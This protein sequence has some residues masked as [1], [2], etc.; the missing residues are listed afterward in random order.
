MRYVIAQVLGD[1]VKDTVGRGAAPRVH[2]HGSEPL[3]DP[4]GAGPARGPDRL[5]DGAP[6]REREVSVE[7]TPQRLVGHHAHDAHRDHDRA[8][9]LP[10]VGP[11]HAPGGGEV[12]TPPQHERQTGHNEAGDH[13]GGGPG[14]Q[15]PC[16]DR[17]DRADP[18]HPPHQAPREEADRERERQDHGVRQD[19]A[20]GADPGEVARR[21]FEDVRPGEVSP[22]GIDRR[23]H[24]EHRAAH[25]AASE[26]P[27]PRIGGRDRG[28][29]REDDVETSEV[30][31]VRAVDRPR[32]RREA[33]AQVG[34]HRPRDPGEAQERQGEH[35]RDGR[36][37]ECPAE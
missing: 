4:T 21:A 28:Q 32:G 26:V 11:G 13:A 35:A 22:V 9:D 34:Q 20:V 1:G 19:V 16:R 24:H 3:A 18:R 31:G 27:R 36:D 8:D 25:D 2:P 30:D 37:P 6:S 7:V 23:D 33:E 17:Q 15:D 12:V 29:D 14:Q 5:P 10:E